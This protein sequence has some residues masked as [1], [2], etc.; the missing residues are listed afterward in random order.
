[1]GTG[2]SGIVRKGV[3]LRVLTS[4]Q[5]SAYAM[6]GLGSVIV[7]GRP[8]WGADAESGLARTASISR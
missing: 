6:G 5:R 7:K 1:M 4:N 8:A 3:T 2:R